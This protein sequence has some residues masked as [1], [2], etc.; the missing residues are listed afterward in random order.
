MCVCVCA[1]VCLWWQEKSCKCVKLEH[2]DKHRHQTLVM[3]RNLKCFH[4]AVETLAL[5][6]S[7]QQY[8]DFWL[9]THEVFTPHFILIICIA[10]SAGSNGSKSTLFL[11]ERMK[12]AA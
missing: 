6:Q 9:H 3:E 12:S 2:N 11:Q 5:S 4:L 8:F 7:R 1:R 10:K